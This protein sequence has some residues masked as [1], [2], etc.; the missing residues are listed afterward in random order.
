MRQRTVFIVK[1]V[2]LVYLL[3]FNALPER[4]RLSTLSMKG[5]LE[6]GT[7]KLEISPTIMAPSG[8]FA[9]S[10]SSK[11]YRV[12]SARGKLRS[13]IDTLNK[14]QVEILSCLN[15]IIRLQPM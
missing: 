12:S 1:V 3:I 8:L 4:M 5:Y 9:P 7:R 15:Q 14:R 2:Y 6:E 11:R 13:V 10:R